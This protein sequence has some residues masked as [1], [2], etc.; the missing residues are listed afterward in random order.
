MWRTELIFEEVDVSRFV[1]TPPKSAKAFTYLMGILWLAAATLLLLAGLAG[2][3]KVN[4]Q[5]LISAWAFFLLLTGGFVAVFWVVFLPYSVARRLVPMVE[6][7]NVELPE[8]LRN[9]R[10]QN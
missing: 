2:L 7:V 6:R 3:S 4:T 8:L 9:V 5:L 1:V 10:N